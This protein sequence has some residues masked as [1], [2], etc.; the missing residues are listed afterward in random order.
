MC[1]ISFDSF[2]LYIVPLNDKKT[3]E[4]R[5]LSFDRDD[6]LGSEPGLEEVLKAKK[7]KGLRQGNP[8][9]LSLHDTINYSL[10]HHL[11]YIHL[12]I[13]A[14][15]LNNIKPVIHS[16]TFSHPLKIFINNSPFLLISICF[17]FYKCLELETFKVFCAL[18]LLHANSS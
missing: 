18:E 9:T 1:D 12:I 2:S 10:F 7:P 4:L 11:L 16:L 6:E 17:T 13:L 3:L 14:Y 5:A 8:S 15:H